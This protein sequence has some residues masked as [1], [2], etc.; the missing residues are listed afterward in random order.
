[1]PALGGPRQRLLPALPSA[2]AAA[3][4][5]AAPG[6][7][8]GGEDAAAAPGTV[9]SLR[10]PAALGVSGAGCGQAEL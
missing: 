5:A 8:P 4:L 9:D 6:A 10:L 2:V 1:M 3:A 7:D